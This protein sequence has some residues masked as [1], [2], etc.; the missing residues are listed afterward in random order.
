MRKV[1]ITH[2]ALFQIKS[3]YDYYCVY[4][5]VKIAKKIKSEIISSIKTLKNKDI[6]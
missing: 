4:A 6:E 5:S 1:V 3:I 2:F